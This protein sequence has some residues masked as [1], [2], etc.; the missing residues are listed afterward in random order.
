MRK[1]DETVH[2][3]RKAKIDKLKP[4]SGPTAEFDITGTHVLPAASNEA[5]QG[6]VQISGY[7]L[8]VP[9]DADVRADDQVTVRGETYSVI[10]KPGKFMKRRKIVATIVTL[11]SSS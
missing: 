5:D 7:T 8:V 2:V 3:I 11:R 6:W 10:G 9:G 4:A 1:G